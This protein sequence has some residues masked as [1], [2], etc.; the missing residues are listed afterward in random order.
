MEQGTRVEVFWSGDNVW[1]PATVMHVSQN[2]VHVL[3]DDWDPSNSTH[4]KLDLR[5]FNAEINGD[6]KVFR[7]EETGVPDSVAPAVLVVPKTPVKSKAAATG[8]VVEKQPTR[9]SQR[10]Q[11]QRTRREKRRERGETDVKL[12]SSKRHAA[13]PKI[14]PEL[15]F[16]TMVK[17]SLTLGRILRTLVKIAGRKKRPNPFQPRPPTA[18]EKKTLARNL[19]YVAENDCLPAEAYDILARVFEVVDDQIDLNVDQLSTRVF[20]RL[21]PMVTGAATSERARQERESRAKARNKSKEGSSSENSSSTTT[22]SA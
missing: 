3:Y 12:P 9:R 21:E 1:F 13:E 8:D 14:T 6:T 16:K 11:C 5:N 20:R 18:K 10:L 15:V 19:R 17:T 22:T 7:L 2:V 4:N